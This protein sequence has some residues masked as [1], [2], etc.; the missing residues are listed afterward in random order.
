MKVLSSSDQ[1]LKG[2]KI[3]ANIL[4][5][6]L[7]TLLIWSEAFVF[8]RSMFK[9][10]F[11]DELV[12]NHSNTS[13]NSISIGDSMMTNRQN[14][15]PST[16]SNVTCES[17]EFQIVL[18]GKSQNFVADYFALNRESTW[19]IYWNGQ[20][21][22]SGCVDMLKSFCYFISPKRRFLIITSLGW[23]HRER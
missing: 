15:I 11:K 2:F 8:Q 16:C 3:S 17:K 20:C 18:F 1:S 6:Y 23:W 12:H 7:K 21:D 14:E 10:A 5:Y 19:R 4:L 13:N 22:S 9:E